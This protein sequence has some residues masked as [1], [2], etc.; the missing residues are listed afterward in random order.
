[1]ELYPLKFKPIF[2]YRIWG[3]DKLKNI[4][5]K[6]YKEDLV[7]ESWEISDVKGFETTVSEGG[8]K[9]TTLNE[10]MVKFKASLLGEAVY[11]KFGCVFP[12][13]IKFIDAKTPLSIQVHP[14]NKL[15]KER[16]NSFGK[17]EMWYIM[18]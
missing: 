6:K 9:G 8:F 3:G 5:N 14:N 4:L 11:E 10:L 2:C 7:G 15:A 17:N 18:Q 1:M 16:H 12:L 13:L